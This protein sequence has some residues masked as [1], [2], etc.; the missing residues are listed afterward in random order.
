[1]IHPET[2]SFCGAP[3]GTRVVVKSETRPVVICEQCVAAA[4][5]LI[6]QHR[7]VAGSQPDSRF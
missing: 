2:C 3:P 6:R 4:A 7:E 5:E 1:M